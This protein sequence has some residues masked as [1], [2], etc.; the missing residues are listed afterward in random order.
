VGTTLMATGRPRALLAYGV[1]HFVAYISAVLVVAHLGLVAVAT[2]AVVVHSAFLVVA[3]VMLIPGS[4]SASLRCFWN[5]IAPATASCAALVAVAAPIGWAVS[6]APVPG[7]VVIAAVGFV[8]APAY[9]LTLRVGF[10]D[11]W[12]DLAKLVGRVLPTSLLLTRARRL[13]PAAAR[14]AT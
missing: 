2:A 1:G 10:K 5:D 9:L 3:Y 14:S 6:T 12:G 8:A 13:S 4:L 7:I 11:A